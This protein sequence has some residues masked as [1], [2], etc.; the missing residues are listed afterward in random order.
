MVV[1]L[2]GLVAKM[3][4]LFYDRFDVFYIRVTELF[5]L[6]GKEVTVGKVRVGDRGED[7]VNG[8]VCAPARV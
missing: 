8:W 2:G 1:W 6:R 5:G 4:V 3:G 7:D